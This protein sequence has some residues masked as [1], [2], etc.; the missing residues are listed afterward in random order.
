M[1]DLNLIDEGG[2]EETSTPS[3]PSPARRG[4]SGG[5]GSM[6]K[7]LLTIL[8][9]L[10][11]G[12]ALFYQYKKGKFPFKKKAPVT[13]VQEEPF[14]D[15]QP[16]A[17]NQNAQQVMQPQDTASVQ[18]LETPLVDETAKKPDSKAAQSGKDAQKSPAE[19]MSMK[20]LTDM[21][22]NYTVQVSAF[23]EKKQ[24]D[25]IVGR[26]EEAGYPAFVETIPMKGVNWYTVRIGHYP[27]RDDAKKAVADFALELRSSYWIDRVR[28][29]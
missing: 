12:T 1:P 9:L 22:G 20:K 18:L 11:V 15:T 23:R 6:N 29:K 24:A 25:E 17:S 14:P 3:A 28:S 4:K 8:V 19:S 10:I 5:G 21:Q 2:I 13:V 27:S 26:L 16:I 7:I